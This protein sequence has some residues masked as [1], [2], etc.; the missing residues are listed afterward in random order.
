[1]ITDDLPSYHDAYQKEFWTNNKN[2][3]VHIRYIYLKGD[4]KD[5]KME[6]WNGSFRDREKTVRGLKKTDSPLI[7]GYQIFH[8]YVKPHIRLD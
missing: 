4:M 8:N 1:M 2:R 6:R 5:N 7:S 3:T